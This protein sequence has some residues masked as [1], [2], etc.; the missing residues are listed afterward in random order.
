VTDRLPERCF[1]VLPGVPKG[2]NVFVCVRGE[3][4]VQATRMDFGDYEAATRVVHELNNALGIGPMAVRAMLVGCL[5]GW[6]SVQ[7]E[8]GVECCPMGATVH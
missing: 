5:T 6:N 1:V 4:G 3:F 7:R 8:F 2:Q